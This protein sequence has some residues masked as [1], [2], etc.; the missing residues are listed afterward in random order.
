MRPSATSRSSARRSSIPA[1]AGGGPAPRRPSGTSAGFAPR[2]ASLAGGGTP[3]DSLVIEGLEER[4]L[5][6]HLVGVDGDRVFVREAGVAEAVLERLPDLAQRREREVAERVGADD[7]ADLLHAAAVG[8][9]LL[10]GRRVDP[11]VAGTDRRRRGDPNV[12]LA[13]AG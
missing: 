7:R 9:E 4:E 8:D 6:R 13:R 1:R 5:R 3:S 10:A 2:R 11:V 12:H